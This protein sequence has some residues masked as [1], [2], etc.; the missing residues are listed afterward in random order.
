MNKGP[1]RESRTV[2]GRWNIRKLK[3]ASKIS[4]ASQ[5]NCSVWISKLNRKENETSSQ[6]K[7]VLDKGQMTTVCRKRTP[8]QKQ[9]YKQEW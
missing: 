9:K 5:V 7:I 1:I 4:M 8:S 2:R 6:T 3:G